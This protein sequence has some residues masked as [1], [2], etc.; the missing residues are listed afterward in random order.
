M[1]ALPVFISGRS[2]LSPAPPRAYPRRLTLQL[3]RLRHHAAT[4]PIT[5]SRFAPRGIR[6]ASRHVNRPAR[7]AV[8]GSIS[9]KHEEYFREETFARTQPHLRLS[10][11]SL[12]RN[13]MAALQVSPGSPA[14]RS[15]CVGQR[16]RASSLRSIDYHNRTWLRQHKFGGGIN[17]IW[18]AVGVSGADLCAIRSFFHLFRRSK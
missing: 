9:R 10:G 7:T 1:P 8:P 4:R 3:V 17:P 6:R 11:F 12:S 2:I 14:S 15:S 5:T 16:G 13:R 18:P